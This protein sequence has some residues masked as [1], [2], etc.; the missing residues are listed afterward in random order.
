VSENQKETPIRDL[1][2]ERPMGFLFQLNDVSYIYLGKSSGGPN[3]GAVY[4]FR[5]IL[6]DEIINL[7]VEQKVKWPF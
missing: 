2:K 1:I 7:D 3:Y 4:Y 6:S 5:E